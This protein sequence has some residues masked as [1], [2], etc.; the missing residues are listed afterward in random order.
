MSIRVLWPGKTKKSYYKSAIDDY[1]ER[2]RRLIDLEIVEIPETPLRD[3]AQKA[4]VRK[5]SQAIRERQKGGP[6][7]YL[8]PDGK[9]I[10][11]EELAQWLE[12]TSCEAEFVL[13]GPHGCAIPEGATKMSF[14]KVT[15]P[16]ELAR[17]VLL[18]QIY[19]A[20]TI[21]RRIPY[22]K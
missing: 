12:R 16:H 13:G 20:L 11:S 9:M 3:K 6:S 14:G 8:D 17:V 1:A 2:I 18:E 4:R 21:L 15:L 5:E 10:T 22:H 19:R 7:V